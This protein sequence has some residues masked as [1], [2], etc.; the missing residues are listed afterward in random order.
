MKKGFFETSD[1]SQRHTEFC[2]EDFGMIGP[3][4]ARKLDYYLWV[5]LRLVNVLQL[6]LPR[7]EIG[8]HKHPDPKTKRHFLVSHVESLLKIENGLIWFLKNPLCST[9][10]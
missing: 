3:V 10:A 2:R 7:F 4:T 6:S 1:N 8:V 5:K 9:K